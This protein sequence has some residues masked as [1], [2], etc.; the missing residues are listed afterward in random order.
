MHSLSLQARHIVCLI[1]TLAA[2]AATANI[3]AATTPPIPTKCEGNRLGQ[4]LP[5]LSELNGYRFASMSCGPAHAEIKY[6]AGQGFIRMELHDTMFEIKGNH[7]AQ[8]S[9]AAL[10][11]FRELGRQHLAAAEEHARYVAQMSQK[12]HAEPDMFPWHDSNYCPSVFAFGGGQAWVFVPEKQD[13]NAA[14]HAGDVLKR[15]YLLSI[16]IKN[17]QAGR[18]TASVRETVNSF[19]NAMHLEKLP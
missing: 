3:F 14:S 15:R 1:A 9:K 7:D 11:S 10:E 18:D 17:P 4:A 13:I 8:L 6:T 5:S 16:E 12:C 2:I 19:L